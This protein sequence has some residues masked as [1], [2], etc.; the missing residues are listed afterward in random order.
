MSWE[1]H[2]RDHAWRMRCNSKIYWSWR[3]H[4]LLFPGWVSVSSMARWLNLVPLWKKPSLLSSSPGE[5]PA[6]RNPVLSVQLMPK[7]SPR[8]RPARLVLVVMCAL[9]GAALPDPNQHMEPM[10]VSPCECANKQTNVSYPERPL[11]SF[12]YI[13]LGFQTAQSLSQSFAGS[14]PRLDASPILWS[15]F[16]LLMGMC[17]AEEFSLY[18][19]ISPSVIS[20]NG[21]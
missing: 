18:Y 19:F 14:F 16:W 4:N 6:S 11:L 5:G 12:Y 9:T 7:L 2:F 20:A 17:P 10:L 3:K 15:A 21:Q 8:P 1:K 13:T